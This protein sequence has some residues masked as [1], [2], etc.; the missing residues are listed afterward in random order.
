M[1][2][3]EWLSS[4]SPDRLLRWLQ[5][6]RHR[7]TRRKLGLFACACARRLGAHVEERVT[8]AGL[9][10]TERMAEG[11]ASQD[12]HRSFLEEAL[13]GIPRGLFTHVALW[14]V[15]LVTPHFS[16]SSPEG[17]ARSVAASTAQGLGPDEP[18]EQAALLR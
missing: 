17:A 18:A 1:T 16:G 14:A 12:E 7:P 15:Q 4:D 5:K 11:T 3:A 9:A 8:A 6:S 2:E 10:L 13:G